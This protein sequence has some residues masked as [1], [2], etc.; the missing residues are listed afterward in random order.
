MK[1]LEHNVQTGEVTER[2]ATKAE[3]DQAKID[4]TAAAERAAIAQAKELAANSA[5]DKLSALGLTADE[6]AALRG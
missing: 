1:I 3:L 6:I 5:I 2:D 4:A